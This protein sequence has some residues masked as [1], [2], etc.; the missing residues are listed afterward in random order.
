VLQLKR[1]RQG[2]AEQLPLLAF[3]LDYRRGHNRLT[4]L[5]AGIHA[6]ESKESI[7]GVI[8]GSQQ[9]H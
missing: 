5:G 2:D 9:V 8:S 7:L 6:G 1:A 4:G 3:R